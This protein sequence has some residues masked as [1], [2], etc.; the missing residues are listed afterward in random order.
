A[1][2]AAVKPT[3]AVKPSGAAVKP[4]GEATSD[5][6]EDKPDAL[7]QP[8]PKPAKP[9][10]GGDAGELVLVTHPSGAAV[11]IDGE[12]RGKSP[13][14]ISLP[15]GTHELSVTRDRYATITQRVEVPN[16]LELTLKRPTATLHIDS[17]PAGGEVVVEGKP[18]GKTPVDVT[19]D[20][21]HHYD[22]EV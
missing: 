14:T 16:K 20:A 12:A 11:S 1:A 6:D 10:K 13:L 18:R 22:V 8:A 19:L 17:E 21:F 5:D 9:A 2:G 7:V 4:S 3:G 15:P